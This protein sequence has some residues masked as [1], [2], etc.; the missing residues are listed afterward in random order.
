MTEFLLTKVYPIFSAVVYAIAL[1]L[2]LLLNSLFLKT[3]RGL[4]YHRQ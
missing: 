4:T 2:P 1:G 3:L